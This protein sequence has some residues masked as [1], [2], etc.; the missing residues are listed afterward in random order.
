MAEPIKLDLRRKPTPVS[1]AA[2]ALPAL[3]GN[4]M[5]LPAGSILSLSDEERRMLDQVNWKAGDPIPDLAAH[6]AAIRQDA[7]SALP[8]PNLPR[9]ALPEEIDINALPPAQREA[10]LQN[11][12][13]AIAAGQ[14]LAALEAQHVQDPTSPEVN[15]AIDEILVG[16]QRVPV[17]MPTPSAPA[18]APAPELP[19]MVTAAPA[20]Q[21]CRNCNHRP[22]EDPVEVTDQDKLDFLAS[23]GGDVRFVREY[24]LFGGSVSAAFRSLSRSELDMAVTQAGCD[25]RDGLIPNQGEFFRAVQNY[26]LA[27]SLARLAVSPNVTNFPLISDVA[28]SPRN[29]DEKVQTPLHDYAPYVNERIGSASL[30]RTLSI[31]YGRFNALVRRLEDNCY[32]ESFWNG[33]ASPT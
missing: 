29:P 22:D 25:D 27:L 3:P 23:M 12:Q 11:V 14:R 1:P 32:N 20:Q 5:P 17:T 13:Q 21:F 10:L 24:K 6:L 2:A 8:D 30:L 7:E 9:V 15:R 28:V 19:V 31:A 18:A 26:E 4:G 16:T 33:I